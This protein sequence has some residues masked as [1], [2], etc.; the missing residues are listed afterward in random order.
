MK[1][2]ILTSE[3]WLAI[4][5]TLLAALA[6]VYASSP[7][8]QVAGIVAAALISAGYGFQRTTIK[9]NGKADP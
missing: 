5:A 3:F 8:A 2:G 4:I 6:I 1:A 9:K 7:L